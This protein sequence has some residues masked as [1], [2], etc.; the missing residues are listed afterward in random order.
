[1]PPCCPA[2]GYT[3]QQLQPALAIRRCWQQVQPPQAQAD[4][5][6]HWAAHDTFEA[7]DLE[8]PWPP[9]WDDQPTH[10]AWPPNIAAQPRPSPGPATPASFPA[11]TS[12]TRDITPWDTCHPVAQLLDAHHNSCNLHWPS[13]GVGNKY[14]LPMHKQRPRPIRQCITHSRLLIYLHTNPQRGTTSPRTRPGPQTSLHS[15][16]LPWVLRLQPVSPH[17]HPPPV[18]SPIEVHATLLPSRWM[19]I[20]AAAT[21]TQVVLLI[22]R[23]GLQ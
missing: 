19:C 13:G 7:A 1:M 9:A 15:R 16:A 4:T 10:K 5:S 14:N 18:T 6:T 17:V 11:R 21:C 23:P 22:T 12:T 20:T 2:A 3:S 8:T